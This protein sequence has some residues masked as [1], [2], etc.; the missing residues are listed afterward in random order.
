MKSTGA[1]GQTVAM[2][3]NTDQ[4]DERDGGASRHRDENQ[5]PTMD[6][7]LDRGGH[8]NCYKAKSRNTIDYKQC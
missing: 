3:V 2:E 1:T 8:N 7:L 5:L 4:I 6:V